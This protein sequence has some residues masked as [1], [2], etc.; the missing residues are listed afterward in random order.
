VVIDDT[1]VRNWYSQM[2]PK[3]KQHLEQ[4]EGTVKHIR[5]MGATQQINQIQEAT[6]GE[7]GLRER[8]Y[9]MDGSEKANFPVDNLP[10]VIK[11]DTFTGRKKEIDKIHNWLGVEDNK[12]LRTYLIYGRRGIG[13]TQ[14]ALEYA[15]LFY[16]FYDAIFWIQCETAAALRQ[17]FAD[18][19]TV[20]E[21]DGADKNGHF[22][23]N[24]MKVNKWLKQTTK[25][26]LLIYDNAER[27]SLLKGSWPVGARGTILLTSRT[28][29]NFFED[30]Q[31][32]G[33]TVPFFNDQERYDFLM[34]Q[35][36]QKWQDTH[37]NP[38]GVMFNT[39][40]TAAKTLLK[41]TGGLPLAIKHAARLILNKSIGVMS[42]SAEGDDSI[43]GFLGVFDRSSSKLPQRQIGPRDPI[44]HALDTIWSIA[45]ESLTDNARAILQVLAL[46][47]PDVISIDLFQPGDQTRLTDKL[48]FCR[49]K[50]LPNAVRPTLETIILSSPE[51]QSA[52]EELTV[53]GMVTRVGRSMAICREVQEA[54]DYPGKDDLRESFDAA[55]NLLY[56]AFPQQ[57]E[58]RLMTEDKEI[59]CRWVQHVIALATK[60]RQYSFEKSEKADP[61]RGMESAQTFVKLLASCAW[62]LY[63]IAD[64]DECLDLINYATA[65]YENQE[66]VGIAHLMNTK[67]LAYYEFNKFKPSREAFEISGQLMKT[68]LGEHHAEYAIS[69]SNLGNVE[70]AK[71]RY[72]E[73]LELLREAA[74][75]REAIGDDAAV[76]L[77][78][79]Y[80]QIG[81][82][83]FL[84]KNYIEAYKEY[85]KCEGILMKKAG[86]NTRFFADLH[87]AY[88]N[89]EYALG[90]YSLAYQ[91]YERARRI[92]L[93]MNP[94]HP[95]TAAVYY[96][97]GCSD[98]KMGRW[99]GALD[100]LERALNIA[101]VRSPNVIDGTIARIQW[102]R[103]EIGL[104]NP[105]ESPERRKEY[106]EIMDDM[107]LRQTTIAETMDIELPGTDQV[108]DR[109]AMF[110][111]LVAG[112]YR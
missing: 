101:K 103:A 81:R 104:N 14:I 82:V 19:A 60:Y 25:R 70:S 32:Q 21:L 34:A 85:Q 30:D 39:E 56:D 83:H 2:Q 4:M 6:R 91:Q 67:G 3:L 57:Q 38:D 111:I 86:R 100:N 53:Q 49:T 87:Y 75:I 61:L 23:E 80:L 84:Q 5:A 73:A 95:V 42:P 48:A 96:K 18:I 40:T 11:T 58:G 66:I 94:L 27:E 99:L 68:L 28:F 72:D 7:L 74:S 93:D 16:K 106:N 64:Y 78:L 33:E 98:F 63:E 90:E 88:G 71:G 29:Y 79:N 51:L 112:H 65:A 59:C 52:I 17:S 37:L 1:F 110:D 77:A 45:F 54:V 55:A 13:K 62:Y 76:L 43:H 26:W 109:E 50:A 36:G 22:E 44:V 15:R 105:T 31:R 24:L 97:I 47:S 20:L 8:E 107:N 89:R 69:R 12:R 9:P 41:E 10:M 35:L 46:V 102:K 108:E 92:C